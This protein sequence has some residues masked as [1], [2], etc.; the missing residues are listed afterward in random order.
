MI[1]AQANRTAKMLDEEKCRQENLKFE[2]ARAE[3]WPTVNRILESTPPKLSESR[4]RQM[5][6]VWLK[7]FERQ[8]FIKI[9][10]K[11]PGIPATSL[12]Q[13]CRRGRIHLFTI[14][15]DGLKKAISRGMWNME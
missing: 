5:T 7:V 14:A 12:W 6:V 4:L 13:A 1:R 11:F 9:G 10:E 3:F 2:E 15:S 8:S